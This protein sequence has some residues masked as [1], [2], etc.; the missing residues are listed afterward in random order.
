MNTKWPKQH[1]EVINA[2]PR[3]LKGYWSVQELAKL[4]QVNKAAILMQIKRGKIVPIDRAG[5]HPVFF[6]DEEVARYLS[7]PYRGGKPRA[8]PKAE[9]H[10]TEPDG[11]E[12]YRAAPHGTE[13]AGTDPAGG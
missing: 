12:P 9:P 5:E 8:V 11:A 2:F 3:R 13:P 1:A 4:L 6:T 7:E 10:G